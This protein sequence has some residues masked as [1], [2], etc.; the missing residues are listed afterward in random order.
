[1]G[2]SKHI[3]TFTDETLLVTLPDL[4]ATY[5]A[6]TLEFEWLISSSVFK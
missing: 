3:S 4:L 1:M 2:V 6:I 5:E